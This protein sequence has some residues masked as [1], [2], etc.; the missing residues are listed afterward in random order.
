LRLLG[1]RCKT[2]LPQTV[3]FHLWHPPVPSFCR[4]AHNTPNEARYRQPVRPD[5]RAV[6]GLRELNATTMRVWRWRTGT[7]TEAPHSTCALA[8]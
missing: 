6:T 3:A 5:G 1:V 2:V 4:N 8:S 7:L